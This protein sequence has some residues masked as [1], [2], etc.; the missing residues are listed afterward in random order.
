MII[1][2]I[3]L[4]SRQLISC[5]SELLPVILENIKMPTEL[6]FCIPEHLLLDRS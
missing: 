1:N 5:R 4:G 6:I 3:P 2:I